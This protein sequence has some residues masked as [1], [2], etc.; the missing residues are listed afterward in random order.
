MKGDSYGTEPWRVVQL[1]VI[2][3]HNTCVLCGDNRSY[4]QA[5]SF[6]NCCSELSPNTPLRVVFVMMTPG[7]ATGH[8]YNKKTDL[9]SLESE[10]S[11]DFRSVFL[12]VIRSGLVTLDSIVFYLPVCL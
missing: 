12:L 6:G 8:H 9:K 1:E 7:P 5:L 2:T 4:H 10:L 11:D 3:K